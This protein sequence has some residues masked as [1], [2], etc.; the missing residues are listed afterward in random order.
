MMRRECSPWTIAPALACCALFGDPGVSAACD[1]ASSP[2]EDRVV[3]VSAADAVAVVEAVKVG[4]GPAS[5]RVVEPLEGSLAK[6]AGIPIQG[7]LSRDE[8]MDR[9]FCGVATMTPG[10]RYVVR[11]FGPVPGR[12]E[13]HLID[14]VGGIS[15]HTPGEEA[16][17][18]QALAAK[19]PSSAWRTSQP[20]VDA[21]LLVDASRASSKGELDLVVLLRNT[22]EAAIELQYR[23]WP[24][25]E[26][27]SCS[28]DVVHIASKKEVQARD[29]PISKKDIADYFSKHGRRYVSK[30]EPGEI[31]MFRLPRVTSAARGWG[32][33]EELGFR[34]YPPTTPGP[35]R[36]SAKCARLFGGGTV[37]TTAAL[38]VRL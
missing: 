9:A 23:D 4:G 17:V 22:G 27:S 24:V 10:Q 8:A 32:Y 19:L 20:G 31:H 37:V 21:K 33:K 6:G 13:Y 12:S 11:L 29:V 35:H 26:R 1:R 3:G 15:D 34:F 2:L 30:I 38:E 7:V 16:S 18:R 14:P 36:V 28:L 25:A 5:V